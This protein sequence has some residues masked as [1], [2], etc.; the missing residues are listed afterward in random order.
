M[1]RFCDLPTGTKFKYPN[2]SDIWIAVETYN[3]GIVAKYIPVSEIVEGDKCHHQSL[4][5]FVDDEWHLE[6]KVEVLE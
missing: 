5:C 3:D 6:S 4:C 2:G 1:H